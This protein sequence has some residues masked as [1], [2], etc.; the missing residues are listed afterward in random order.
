MDTAR[1]LLASVFGFDDFRPGQ[2]EIIQA[3]LDGEDALAIMPTGGGKSLCFQL[4]AI[5]RDGLTLVISPLIALMRDQ[6]QALRQYGVEAGALTSANDPQ[7]N[8]YV[9]DAID[10]G[11]LKLLY[12]APER[13]GSAAP[14]LA[15]ADVRFLAVDEAH[16]VSQWGHDFRPDYLR[17]G[18]LRERLGR[19]QVAAFTATADEETR[20]EIIRKLF[21]APPRTFLRGFDRPNIHLAFAAKNGP[22]RQLLDFVVPRKGRSGIVYASS[23]NKTEVLAKA[24][25]DAGVPALP[26]HAGLP[27]EQRQETQDRFQRE[28]DLA[29]CATIAFGMGVDKPDIRWVAHADLPKSM[30]SYYQE[31]GRAG[32]DGAPAE[33]LTLYGLDDIK[34]QRMRIDESPAPDDRKRADHARLNALLALAEAPRCRRQILL[35]YFG[36]ESGPCGNCDLCNTPPK[37]F[38]GTEAAQMALSAI[39]RTEE[40]YGQD[41]IISVLRGEVTDK[42][43]RAGH[44]DLKVFGMGRDKSKDWWRGAMRQ[45]YALGLTW[46]DAERYGA[47]RL[48]E[49]ARPVLRGETKIE[50][51]ADAVR[52]RPKRGEGRPAPAALV[53]EADEALFTAL[54]AVRTRLASAQNVPAYVV[55]ADRTLIDMAAQRPQTLDDLGKCYGV[56]GKKLTRYGEAFLEALRGGG[57]TVAE[58]PARLRLAA[59]DS[60]P[61]FDALQ[62]AQHELSRGADGGDKF[63]SCTRATLAKIAEDRPR[64]IDALARVTGMGDQKAERFGAVFLSIIEAHQ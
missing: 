54:R 25:S 39:Y 49:E 21:D 5:R 31:I 30:E 2:A 62:E 10:R 4:P 61:L 35:A 7:E 37:L 47:W 17:I 26:Y 14:L 63:L 38:D 51:R 13:L 33:T 23:R 34:L 41:H 32:R 56:G 43:A 46:I 57:A 44:D 3:V 22:R 52:D 15:R 64:S 40:R 6:V 53:D 42:V 8:E 48:S 20:A 16:C 9:F 50:M 11:A 19:P 60:G 36:D 24:L 55:F 28:D 58:H 1:A 45:I 59:G 18:E 27:P 12:L 29:I